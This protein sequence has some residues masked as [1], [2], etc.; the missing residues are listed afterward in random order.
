MTRHAFRWTVLLLVIVALPTLAAAQDYKGKGR[1]KGKV[2]NA[3][4][5]GLKDSMVT[6]IYTATGT[7]PDAVKVKGNGEFEVKDLMPGTWTLTANAG[8]LNYG[9]EFAEVEILER[10]TPEIEIVIQPAQTLLQEGTTKLQAKNFGEARLAFQKLLI[11]MPQN[12]PLNQY[13][14]TTY[15][16]EGNFGKALEHLDI[17]LSALPAGADPNA[18]RQLKLQA[19]DDAASLPD[20]PRMY[21]YIESLSDAEFS[22]ATATALVSVAG[23]TLS[24]SQKNYDET[25]KLLDI[26]VD[27]VPTNALAYYYR[28]M[29]YVQLENDEQ[30]KADLEK[31]VELS[32]TETAQVRQA[33]TVLEQMNPGS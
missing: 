28:G 21:G 20:Y 1:I 3:E 13:I 4:G 2:V 24:G 11:A 32:P 17:L 25:V 18:V 8:H 5:Q 6:A 7:G 14:A 22:D 31:C 26:V 16:G 29:A 10:D 30:A 15:E 12:V 19:V 9:A 27:K 23:N 33:K